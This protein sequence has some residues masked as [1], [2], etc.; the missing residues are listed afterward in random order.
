V[1]NPTHDD[2]ALAE[3]LGQAC[4]GTPIGDP[5][6]EPAA[7]SALDSARAGEGLPPLTLASGFWSLPYGEQQFILINEERVPRGLAPIEG[8]VSDLDQTAAQGA[9]SLSDPQGPDQDNWVSNWIE[10]ANTVQAEFLFM[11]DDGLAANSGVVGG[12]SGCVPGNTSGCWGHRDNTLFPWMSSA[13][14]GASCVTVTEPDHPT[15]LS[16][17]QLFVQETNPG[18]YVMTW[19]QAVEMG[20]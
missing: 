5:T 4:T 7:L 3:Q 8:L 16:C 10:S 14:M 17:A 6:C 15:V 13:Q 11:Y 9:A 2:T 1:T 20:Y 19:T 18:T 12:N